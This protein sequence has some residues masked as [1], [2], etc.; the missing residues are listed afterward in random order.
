VLVLIVLIFPLALIALAALAAAVSVHK[1]SVRITGEGVEIRNS[2]Q[3]PR[4]VP[5]DAVDGF[6]EPP[7]VG[8]FAGLRPRTAVLV[9]RD[10]SRL[11]VRSLVEPD[12]GYG[13]DA[14]NARVNALRRSQPP[15]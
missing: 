14:L 1:S 9:L 6:V 13:I 2:G 10:G 5:L 4:L 7:R 11:P 8:S 3:E 15:R 12:A